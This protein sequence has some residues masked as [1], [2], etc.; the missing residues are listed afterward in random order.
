MDF[1][2]MPTIREVRQDTR[3]ANKT[4]LIMVRVRDKFEVTRV[5]FKLTA[6]DGS[7]L[8]E[9]ETLRHEYPGLFALQIMSPGSMRPGNIC[10]IWVSDRPGNIIEKDFLLFG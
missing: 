1:M 5:G 4:P 2:T 7:L 3:P 9:A 6:P 8:E 10:R